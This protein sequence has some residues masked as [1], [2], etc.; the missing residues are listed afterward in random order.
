MGY[1]LLCKNCHYLK[2]L[3]TCLGV[4][5]KKESSKRFCHRCKREMTPFLYPEGRNGECKHCNSI[6][7]GFFMG[8][9]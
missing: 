3:C 8:F 7:D 4:K 5:E 6:D 1:L 2:T 9:R